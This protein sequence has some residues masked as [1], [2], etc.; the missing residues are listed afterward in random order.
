[1]SSN[2]P[3]PETKVLAIASH[4]VY[5]YVGNTMAALVMQS[6][7]CDVAALNTVQ[8]S[9]HKG[10]RQ[11]KGST[12]P[13]SEIRELYDGLRRPALNDF[14]MMLSGYAMDAESV[15]AI[16]AIARDLRLKSNTKPGSFF[17][18]LDPVMGDQGHLYVNGNLVPAY[19]NLLRDADLILPNQYEL[20]WLA[21]TPI[22]SISSVVDAITTLHRTYRTPHIVVTSV[23]FDPSNRYLSV[24]GSTADSTGAPRLFQIDVP[25]IDAFFSGT[26]DMFAALTV[27]RLREAVSHVPD[28]S[29]TRSWISPDD[30]V[31]VDLP[32]AQAL[33]KVLGS[34][35]AILQKTK[36]ARDRE[37]ATFSE[38]E[39]QGKEGHVRTTKASEV[40]LVRNLA[41]LR[42]PK[43]EFR[44]KTLSL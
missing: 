2:L 4:V 42:D 27:V 14:D 31:A 25:A 32:L 37:L 28:L 34:M 24:I 8:L 3:V 21:E 41:D 18:V 44:A 38:V 9:N 12:I 13:A 26:G 15:E 6:L 20:G 19:T 43:V 30:V 29:H 33:E 36:E 17:W 35:H 10:Y 23:C 22:N 1:M 11:T 16:G 7:G 40:R 5:G 39:M